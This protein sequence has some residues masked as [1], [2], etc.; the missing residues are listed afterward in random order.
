MRTG[1]H[2]STMEHRRHLV[3]RLRLRGLTVREIADELA[4][5]GIQCNKS[6]VSRDLQAIETDWRKSSMRDI[7]EHKAAQIAEL[8]E[9]R[10]DCWK[11]RDYRGIMRSLELEVRILGTDSPIQID[12]R[13]E[14]EQMGIDAGELF[15]EMVQRFAEHID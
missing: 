10:R 6:T 7:A 12:W 5:Q 11:Y 13:R 9:V 4:E 3:A 1:K 8:R 15:E 2:K 14:V